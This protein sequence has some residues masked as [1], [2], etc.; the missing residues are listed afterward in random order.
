MA[1]QT[2]WKIIAKKGTNFELLLISLVGR[3]INTFAE[4]NIFGSYASG[5]YRQFD[6]HRDSKKEDIEKFTRRMIGMEKNKPGSILKSYW[7]YE[8]ALLKIT[9]LANSFDKYDF[10]DFSNKE[11]A[12]TLEKYKNTL[13]E[14]MGHLYNY[15]FYQHLGEELYNAIRS[16]E[17]DIHK[18]TELF[19]ILSQ[20]K[21]LSVMQKEQRK[22]W[23]V[24]ETISRNKLKIDGN[25]TKLLI[26]KHLGDFSYMGMYY[27][28]GK[29]WT[30]SH[31]LKRIKYWRKQ[32][33]K[34]NLER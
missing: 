30:R 17:K 4:K 34:K 14:H 9:R 1:Q 8:K 5:Y 28:K 2:N 27:F 15:Y 10:N 25:Q 29:P 20:A 24:I 31:I 26:K 18:Q 33:Y 21:R 7:I 3:G 6:T 32:G 16:K 12:A 19:E 13:Y 22:L 23:Q 11:L